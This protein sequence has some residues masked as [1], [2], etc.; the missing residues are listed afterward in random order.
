MLFSV[1][2][3]AREPIDHI[4]MKQ[5]YKGRGNYSYFEEYCWSQRRYSEGRNGSLQKA[6]S[7][8]GTI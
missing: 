3:Q 2:F 8:L 7:P 4:G 1:N 6:R 5:I